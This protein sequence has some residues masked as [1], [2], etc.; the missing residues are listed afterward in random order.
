MVQATPHRVPPR[1]DRR[2]LAHSRTR[3]HRRWART[4]GG[5]SVLRLARCPYRRH[6]AVLVLPGPSRPR[7]QPSL[8]LVRSRPCPSVQSRRC[9]RR[10]VGP[11][12][13]LGVGGGIG[14]G[15]FH[16]V[17]CMSGG[18]RAVCMS[19]VVQARVT[20]VL[21][22]RV[23]PAPGIGAGDPATLHRVCM[24]APLGC[25]VRCSCDFG[26]RC[27]LVPAIL[28]PCVGR[29]CQSHADTPAQGGYAC[30]RR[31]RR[32]VRH[33]RSCVLG[34][35]VAQCCSPPGLSRLHLSGPLG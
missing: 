23:R 2:A 3:W 27:G 18:W 10:A 17:D 8:G 31:R 25:F 12:V 5:P 19:P 28:P 15:Y 1:R 14:T 6:L 34:V 21:A 26:S 35:A 30:A 24:S 9:Q 16:G 4:C 22:L 32:C 13:A 11:G 33:E 20:S 29:A 7:Q